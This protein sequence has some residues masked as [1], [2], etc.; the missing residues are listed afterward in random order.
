VRKPAIEARPRREQRLKNQIYIYLDMST[1][2]IETTKGPRIIYEVLVF[3]TGGKDRM[4]VDSGS[5]K[6]WWMALE[7]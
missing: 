6:L 1:N 4:V 3:T 2:N 5:G 7:R